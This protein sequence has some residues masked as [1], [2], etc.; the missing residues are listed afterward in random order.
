MSSSGGL[1]DDPVSRIGESES[2]SV[3]LKIKRHYTIFITWVRGK[4]RFDFL[5]LEKLKKLD[6]RK[7]MMK[8]NIPLSITQKKGRTN[9]Q[10]NANPN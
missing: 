5:E 9:S 3:N 10:D 6:C 8:L 7:I 4:K 1:R 2:V